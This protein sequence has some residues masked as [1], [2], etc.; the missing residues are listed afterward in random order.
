METEEKKKTKKRILDENKINDETQN[1]DVEVTKETEA[2]LYES[3]TKKEKDEIQ[4]TVSIEHESKLQDLLE[5]ISHD[6]DMARITRKHLL[7]YIIDKFCD[8]YNDADIQAIRKSSITDFTL[9]ELEYREIKKTG[10]MPEALRE[11]LWKSRNLTQSPKKL[12]KS[13]QQEYI[14]DIHKNEEVA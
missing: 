5:T 14:N 3:N 4:V 10:F 6:F 7:A 11:Y 12:R 13:R 9:L 2:I 1:N 8:T